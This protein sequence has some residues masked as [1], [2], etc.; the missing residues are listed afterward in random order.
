MHEVLQEKIDQNAITNMM[1]LYIDLLKDPLPDEK[2][3]LIYSLMTMHHIIDTEN[4]LELS[5]QY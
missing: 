2:F 4:I 3:D 1:P 5:V